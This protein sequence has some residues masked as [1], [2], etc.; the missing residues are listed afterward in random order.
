MLNQD[1]VR[2]I[3][4]VLSLADRARA[5]AWLSRLASED[6]SRIREVMK[7]LGHVSADEYRMAIGSLSEILARTDKSSAQIDS[8]T[9]HDTR[10]EGF[11]VSSGP[12]K[13]DR[14]HEQSTEHADLEMERTVSSEEEAVQK[15]P[16]T[17]G[18]PVATA[19]TRSDTVCEKV[20]LINQAV[21]NF[22]AV[23]L[24]NCLALEGPQTIAVLMKI[25]QEEARVRIV[26]ALSTEEAVEVF[27]I[28]SR[29]QQVAQVVVE[30][31]LDW[32]VRSQTVHASDQGLLNK[33]ALR[34]VREF[35]N[36]R[37]PEER[38]RFLAEL[39]Q[40]DPALARELSE[41]I[42]REC[43]NEFRPSDLTTCVESLVVLGPTP[44]DVAERGLVSIPTSCAAALKE[45]VGLEQTVVSSNQIVER[46]PF[47]SSCIPIELN[48]GWDAI[49]ELSDIDLGKIIKSVRPELLLKILKYD[50][51]RIRSRILSL[52]P[53]HEQHRILER[54]ESH[55]PVTDD[56]FRRGMHEL[57]TAA[58]T[59][60]SQGQIAILYNLTV[61]SAA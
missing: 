23:E 54:I 24:K 35:M 36:G 26:S 3:A 49:I 55:P 14:E 16:D 29:I 52:F 4:I 41:N 50:A 30:E 44:D 58:G 48:I 61:T 28:F 21:M 31:L 47:G 56:D 22:E 6:E 51:G 37:S 60:F 1:R 25:L 7:K 34:S 59:L 20:E 33:E 32:L 39:A 42:A 9:L 10:P 19:E 46:V 15:F 43:W 2:Q 8:H 18:A 13:S 27:S 45:E 38:M 53:D 40:R 57:E 17:R 11:G 5:D 12:A